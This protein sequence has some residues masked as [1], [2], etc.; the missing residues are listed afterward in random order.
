[1]AAK[2]K[3]EMGSNVEGMYARKGYEGMKK[4]GRIWK[5]GQRHKQRPLKKGRGLAKEARKSG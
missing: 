2:N 1:M 3:K 4:E 5:E